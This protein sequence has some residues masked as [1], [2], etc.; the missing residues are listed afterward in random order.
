MKVIQMENVS[1][2]FNKSIL[3][4]NVNISFDKGKIYGVFGPNGSG[5]SVLFK[6]I[7]GF[8]Q[9]D[10][11]K[12]NIHSDFK[13]PKDNFPKS[14]GIIIDHPA[15][16]ANKTGFE[17][18]K[19]LAIIQDKISDDDIIETMNKVGLD[20]K[21]K[22]KVKHYSIG[23][24][25]KLSIAQAIMENQQLLILDEPFNGLDKKSVANMRQLFTDLNKTEGKT[26]IFTSHNQ[27]DILMLADTIYEIDNQQISIYHN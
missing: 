15:Y 16:I 17:N 1:K 20:W 25:Q 2:G 23:M 21:L 5:K 11:G 18:L 19:R 7:C 9:P 13:Q 26:I 12:V 6:I 8:I 4:K 3:F 14:C 22:Q 10:R 27:E 24:K